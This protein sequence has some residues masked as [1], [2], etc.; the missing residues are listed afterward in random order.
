MKRSN[1][2]LIGVAILVI[3]WVMIDGWYQV[4]AYNEI[5]SGK[6]CS[7]AEIGGSFIRK[8]L[9]AFKN[10][11]IEVGK[12]LFMINLNIHKS[13]NHEL[14]FFKDLKNGISYTISADTLYVKVRNENKFIFANVTINLPE[15]KSVKMSWAPNVSLADKRF[16][17]YTTIY[18]FTGKSLSFINSGQND[19]NIGDNKLEKLELRGNY[20]K[21]DITI[22]SYADVDSLDFD[23]DANREGRLSF[24]YILKTPIKENPNQWINIKVPE[25]FQ[26][27]AYA[28]I[29]SKIITKKSA[30][31]SDFTLY[32]DRV[33]VYQ[34]Y[35]IQN[36]SQYQ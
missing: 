25:Y 5:K 23:I 16:D 6:E 32:D 10:I 11:K 33:N 31:G 29:A 14:N 21:S 24:P 20:D 36:Q 28:K 19:I 15:L 22:S 13:E 4:R 8:K 30:K 17:V 26:V 2:L 7:Y 1:I 9:T 18:G 12:N 27:Q 3:S 35:L 34:R